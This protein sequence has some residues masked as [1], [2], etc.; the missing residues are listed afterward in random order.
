M[1]APRALLE[2]YVAAVLTAPHN[3]SLTATRDPREFWQRH[4][5]DSLKLADLLPR[6][7]H[8]KPLRVLDIGSGCGVPGIPVAIAVPSWRV[9]M[10]ES[11]SKKCGF[12]DAFCTS[13]NIENASVLLGRAE[14]FAHHPE[15]REQY[16]IVFARALAKLPTALELTVPFLKIGGTLVIPHGVTASAELEMAQIAL[17]KLNAHL[18]DSIAYE[19]VPKL[20]FTALIFSKREETS[21]AFPRKTGIPSKRPL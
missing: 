15:H 16:D 20:K 2:K 4:I 8:E 7:M 12:L 3:L 1:D 19:V 11:N 18:T 5:L 17:R 14:E 21:E 10:L 9:F 13:A 6:Q